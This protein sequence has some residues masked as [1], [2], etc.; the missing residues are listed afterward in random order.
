[1]NNQVFAGLT[2]LPMFTQILFDKNIVSNLVTNNYG[3]V[4]S[5]SMYQ[6]MINSQTMKTLGLNKSDVAAFFRSEDF[7]SLI[8]SQQFQAFASNQSIIQFMSNK[9]N[10]NMLRKQKL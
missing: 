1:M 9:E 8:L 2:Q 3:K 4:E 5:N 10:L 6:A 7:K